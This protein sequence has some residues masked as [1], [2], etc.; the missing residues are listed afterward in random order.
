MPIEIVRN[1]SA[2]SV[3][4]FSGAITGIGTTT[5]IGTALAIR[6]TINN[7]DSDTFITAGLSTGYPIY[8]FN[9][10]VGNG[11]TAIN[12]S[13]ANVIGIGSTYLDCIYRVSA[14]SGVVGDD[15]LGIITCNVHSKS[16]LVGIATTGTELSP[17][18]NF[19][20]GRLGGFTRSSNPISIAMSTFVSDVG[21]TTYPTIQRRSIGLKLR[22]E[23]GSSKRLT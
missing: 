16:N 7:L 3:K 20:W 2:A 10:K 18:G 23:T 6:F 4:G 11:I 8:I 14:W 1:V 21:L 17:V 12:S 13:D 15:N 19:S 5:G 9:T 22:Y